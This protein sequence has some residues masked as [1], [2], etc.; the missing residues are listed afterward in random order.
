MNVWVKVALQTLVFVLLLFGGAGTIRWPAGWIFLI[1]FVGGAALMTWR[2]A[3]SDPE[4]LR[5]RLKPVVQKDQ[6]VWDKI[7][8]TSLLVLCPAWLFLLGLDAVRY[9]WTALPVSLQIVGALGLA[10]TMW[11][12]DRIARAN[13][14]LAPV[15]KIQTERGHRVVST[16]PYAVI[17][18]PMYATALFVFPAVALLLRSGWGLATSILLDALL[19]FRTAMEDRELQRGLQGYVAYAQRVR[20]RLVPFIW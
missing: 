15:V 1:I 11:M 19:V 7:L 18:H 14:F 12:F 17:R 3:A 5:E 13:T 8:M 10:A 4:L 6:P 2:L 16:G 20:Y 9:R